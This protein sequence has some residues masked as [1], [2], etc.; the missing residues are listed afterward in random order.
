VFFWA[1]ALFTAAVTL[2]FWLTPLDLLIAHAF[3]VPELAA[4]EH[5][6]WPA[7]ESPLVQALYQAAPLLTLSIGLPA[8][9][10]A[11]LGGLH[12]RTRPWRRDATVLA[13]TVLLGPGLLVNGIFKEHADRPRPV[14]TVGLGGTAAY[15]PPFALPGPLDD[16]KSLPCGHCSVGFALIALW[17]VWTGRHLWLARSALALALVLGFA[18][19]YA[20]VAAG[21]HWPSD[22]LL[23]AAMSAA[24][25]GAVHFG[26]LPVAARLN[27]VRFQRRWRL[28]PPTWRLGLAWGGGL[29]L[30]LGLTLGALL[31]TPFEQRLQHQVLIPASTPWSAP[32]LLLPARGQGWPVH[33]E[34]GADLGDGPRQILIEGRFHGFGLGRGL[35]LEPEGPHRYRLRVRGVF[36]ELHGELWVR[37]MPAPP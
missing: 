32:E 28:L 2:L 11:L 25:A 3:Y 5:A 30:V 37:L 12:P 36:T 35:V 29:V 14:Q 18:L 21:G 7:R 20:R 19:G 24:T 23:A 1:L 10:L 13:L 6:G 9:G 33:L 4:S 31:A 15:T 26:L 17:L 22:V 27:P 8:L 34:T 16:G